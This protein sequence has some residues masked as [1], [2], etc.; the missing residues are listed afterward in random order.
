MAL[1]IILN[2][3]TELLVCGIRRIHPIVNA[4]VHVARELLELKT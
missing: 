1:R 3:A 2:D 4:M